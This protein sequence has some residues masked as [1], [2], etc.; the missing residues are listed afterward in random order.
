MNLSTLLNLFEL[1]ACQ[2]S[3]PSD[4]T[5]SALSKWMLPESKLAHAASC[6][7]NSHKV[8]DSG[9]NIFGILYLV[10]IGLS[11]ALVFIPARRQVNLKH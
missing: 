10:Y 4:L 6:I 9:F 1:L 3:W 2:T 11:R 7:T 5:H 8:I